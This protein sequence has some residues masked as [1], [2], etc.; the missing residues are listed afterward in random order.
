MGLISDI[1]SSLLD[2]ATAVAV[3]LVTDDLSQQIPH[4]VERLID[5]AV[6]RLPD[7]KDRER[8]GE[9]WRSHV[10]DTPGN[11]RKVWTALDCLRASRSIARAGREQPAWAVAVLDSLAF[12]GTKI[13]QRPLLRDLRNAL[14]P[15]CTP[16]QCDFAL[17]QV[18]LRFEPILR[19]MIRAS[20][21]RFGNYRQLAD[22][23]QAEFQK[24]ILDFRRELQE[25]ARGNSCLVTTDCTET[26]A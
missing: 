15:Q 25:Q 2:V 1:A 19:S 6:N 10:A 24:V 7:A 8:Y 22:D 17:E 11:L 26:G 14:A 13:V 3:R 16:A 20:F 9:E 12:R 5:R 18:K 21:S 23:A 4:V